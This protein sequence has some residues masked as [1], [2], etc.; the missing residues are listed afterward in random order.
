MVIT[1]V[2]IFAPYQQTLKNSW[3]S[4]FLPAFLFL[5]VV[6]HT[7]ML[8]SIDLVHHLAFRSTPSELYTRP[9]LLASRGPLYAIYRSEQFYVIT[10][11]ILAIFVNALFITFS[12]A[13]G[14]VQVVAILVVECLVLASLSVLA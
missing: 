6:G 4:I 2:A 9:R 10:P 7:A 3:S 8:H 14:V 12:H 13:N 1:P 11:L 5:A